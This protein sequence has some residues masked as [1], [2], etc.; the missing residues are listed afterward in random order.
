MKPFASRS[1]G[2]PGGCNIAQTKFIVS[3][4][5]EATSPKPPRNVSTNFAPHGTDREVN[6]TDEVSE[7]SPLWFALFSTI[8]TLTVTSQT[9]SQID[10]ST[11]TTVSK[12]WTPDYCPK[13]KTT[14][15]LPPSTAIRGLPE[16]K[17]SIRD[18]ARIP[19]LDTGA[20]VSIIS[21]RK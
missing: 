3:G 13:N 2:N 10:K 14:N 21:I 11:I 9:A 8:D 1:T 20:V 16:A 5:S 6:R 7:A 18:V 4:M 15:T 19:L 12:I 17:M